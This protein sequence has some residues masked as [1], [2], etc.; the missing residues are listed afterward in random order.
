MEE[1]N[2]KRS[3]LK[4]LYED[5]YKLLLI[6][7][8]FLLF[9]AICQIAYQTAT[10]GDFILKDVSLKGGLT[11]SIQK[12]GDVK[13]LE[14]YL[15]EKFP[16]GDINVRAISKTG[17]QTGILVEA[18]EMNPDL[19]INEISSKLGGLEKE[20]YNI[21]IVGGSLG[22][23]FFK[24]TFFALI[25]SFIF[26]AIV[27]FAYFRTFVPSLAVVLAALSDI[28]MTIALLN[29]LGIKMGT[30]GV[31]ALL[32][33]IGYSVD[34]DILL[35]TRVLR[36]KGESIMSSI[37][38]AIN[39]GM[40]MTLTAIVALVVALIFGQSEVIKQIML[41]LLIGLIFD[42][43]NTWIQNVAILR[44]YLERKGQKIE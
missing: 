43:L 35:S 7:P 36:R 15:K 18:S 28:I 13:D 1:Q 37:Y 40:T 30:A 21:E 32:M 22:K 25:F 33:L 6:I 10:T 14:G 38:G 42:I 9:A 5:K 8:I 2:T 29:I 12:I 19:L 17:T 31:A 16:S 11:I 20:D 27:V 44:W 23:S 39:T 24:E 34:T 4:R 26:M 3:F 41:I